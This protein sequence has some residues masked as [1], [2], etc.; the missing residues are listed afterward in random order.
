[1]LRPHR[2]PAPT[3][4]GLFNDS[5]YHYKESMDRVNVSGILDTREGLLLVTSASTHRK[6][7][8]SLIEAADADFRTWSRG[9]IGI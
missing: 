4:H 8:R 1:M 9:L 6:S 5:T 2:S 3:V 7:A